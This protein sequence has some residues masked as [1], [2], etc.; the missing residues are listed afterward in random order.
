MGV[1]G[2]AR[3]PLLAN[4]HFYL[5]HCRWTCELQQPSNRRGAAPQSGSLQERSERALALQMPLQR[6]SDSRR[7]AA[8][9]LV[10]RSVSYVHGIAAVRAWH[11][12]NET[13]R[14]RSAGT[15]LA[16]CSSAHLRQMHKKQQS[17][18]TQ[19][20]GAHAP[21]ALPVR[22]A[23]APWAIPQPL[24]RVQWHWLQLACGVAPALPWP[25]SA[26]GRACLS[27]GHAACHTSGKRSSSCAG[28]PGST[29]TS[30]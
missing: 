6:R 15:V 17:D 29:E 25:A 8:P 18:A 4:P 13:C 27:C 2:G 21:R 5:P 9:K 14:N 16:T 26:Q 19:A 24:D 30:S 11:Q 22:T 3:A 1:G 23:Q 12:S 20:H 10:P 7:C 28:L